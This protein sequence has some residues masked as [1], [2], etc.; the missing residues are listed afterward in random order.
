MMMMMVVTMMMMVVTM[1]IKWWWRSKKLG[2]VA[3]CGLICEQSFCTTSLKKR[4]CTTGL[5]LWNFIRFVKK[6]IKHFSAALT[7]LTFSAHWRK[8]FEQ[9]KRVVCVTNK[10][11]HN[12]Q[13]KVMMMMAMLRTHPGPGASV[14][15]RAIPRRA[16]L[17]RRRS[18]PQALFLVHLGNWWVSFVFRQN[19][20]HYERLPGW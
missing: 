12:C 19:K 2:P 9:M 5:K 15:N 20:A 7:C 13:W 17:L 1:T 6:T 18:G 8:T 4:F 16:R 10:K 14:P 3:A 11:C